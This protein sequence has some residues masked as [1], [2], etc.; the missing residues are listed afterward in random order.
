[1]ILNKLV[2]HNFLKYEHLELISLP[3]PGIVAISGANESGKSTIGEAICFSLFGRTFLGESTRIKE[4]V[5]WGE[6]NGNVMLEFQV[7]GENWT[8]YREIDSD[9][10]HLAKL[11]RSGNEHDATIGVAAVNTAIIEL[12]GCDFNRFVDSFYLGQREKGEVID[13]PETIKSLIGLDIVEEAR[14]KLLKRIDE[15]GRH[16][17]KH[18]ENIDSLRQEIDALGVTNAFLEDL[19]GQ[20]R[21]LEGDR[22][23]LT[24]KKTRQEAFV[25]GVTKSSVLFAEIDSALKEPP[26]VDLP[27]A[28][29]QLKI[30]N[31]CRNADRVDQIPADVRALVESTRIEKHQT[32]LRRFRRALDGWQKVRDSLANYRKRLEFLLFPDV[33]A[34]AGVELDAGDKI[35]ARIAAAQKKVAEATSSRRPRVVLFFLFL[36]LAVVSWTAWVALFA[37]FASQS[38]VLQN[39]K[40]NLLAQI[41]A[42]P[43]TSN[44]AAMLGIS[45]GLTLLALIF[46]VTASR[47]GGKIRDAQAAV[48]REEKEGAR[49]EAELEALK[50]IEEQ[51]QT[52]S[53]IVEQAEGFSGREIS[54]TLNDLREGDGILLLKSDACMSCIDSVREEGQS[55][56]NRLNACRLEQQNEIGQATK[57]LDNLL[58]QMGKKEAQIQQVRAKLELRARQERNVEELE[59][60]IQDLAASRDK[61]QLAAR[62]AEGTYYYVQ[63]RFTPEL[64]RFVARLLPVIT[65]GKYQHNQIDE[66]FSIKVFSGEK[67]NFL[68]VMEISGGTYRQLLL[69]IRL[70]L[71]QALIDTSVRDKQFVFLDEPF[72]FFD[73]QRATRAAMA[74]PHI[75]ERLTQFFVVAQQFADQIEFDLALRPDP[76]QVVLTNQNQAGVS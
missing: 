30:E 23:A 33:L 45:G 1:M 42:N 56:V 71:A 69:C 25:E 55:L 50:G 72:A 44:S 74:L 52:A 8:V 65:D 26:A 36:V 51:A 7:R 32:Q 3:D 76:A 34:P 39:L 60:R 4:L 58:E 61:A 20:K 43:V 37:D 75:S 6:L 13:R 66:D 53:E 40:N 15:Y 48:A 73:D 11:Y 54:Q 63:K 57:S 5:R 64:R 31:L 68:D 41:P 9:G 70:A 46:L 59:H 12:G 27:L 22:T 14:K 19:E 67:N 62:L 18:E 29:V 49:L 28:E 17:L 10:N 47:A 21:A 2:A 24:E 16:I 35:S 38:L